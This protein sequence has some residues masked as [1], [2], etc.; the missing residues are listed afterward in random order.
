VFIA[1]L[2]AGYLLT[3]AIQA[4]AGDRSRRVLAVGLVASVL[5]DIDLLWFYLVDGRRT[6]HHA[7]VTH[8]PLFWI[9]VA[10]LVRIAA[11]VLGWRGAGLLI[12]VALA[13]LLLHMALDSVAAGIWWLWPLAE[14][15]V[16]LVRV[17]AGQGWWV[18]NFVLHWTFLLELALVAA[19][20]AL[21]WSQRRGRE[22]RS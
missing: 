15:E 6:V 21:W 10:V 3:R 2:P 12:A 19:A 16:N 9:A 14:V 20:A 5:P 18:W 8:L 17:P 7:Y 4:R 13:N 22:A 1:H 11:R